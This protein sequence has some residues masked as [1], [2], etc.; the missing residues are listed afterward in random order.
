MYIC[1]CKPW[2]VHG[3]GPVPIPLFLIYIRSNQ[4][5]EYLHGEPELLNNTPRS[6]YTNS[7]RQLQPQQCRKRGEWSSPWNKHQYVN[8]CRGVQTA[9]WPSPRST[10][11]IGPLTIEVLSESGC[12]WAS[13]EPVSTQ[14]TRQMCARGEE[15]WDAMATLLP[16]S[17]TIKYH[18]VRKMT[19]LH[20]WRHRKLI[21]VSILGGWSKIY[22]VLVLFPRFEK[23]VGHRAVDTTL[24]LSTIFVQY[25]FFTAITFLLRCH[26]PLK[27]CGIQ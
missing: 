11:G 21:Y 9:D 4:G 15:G 8:K 5:T 14:E 27:F 22:L 18:H 19:K 1:L 16:C 26:S 23:E 2:R 6:Q 20:T 25:F 7:K 17:K 13:R 3:S 10:P 24:P 12:D